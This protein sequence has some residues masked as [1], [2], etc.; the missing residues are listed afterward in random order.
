MTFSL[1]FF[2]YFIHG[3]SSRTA[4][5]PH[6]PVVIRNRGRARGDA[7]RQNGDFRSGSGVVPRGDRETRLLLLR[8]SE[9]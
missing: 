4:S 7:A 1:I 8:D 5:S 2:Q 9:N 3:N 6:L